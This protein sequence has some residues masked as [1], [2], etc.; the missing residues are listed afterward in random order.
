MSRIYVL[1]STIKKRLE[2]IGYPMTCHKC[3]KRLEANDEV[4]SIG[5]HGKSRRYHKSCYEGMFV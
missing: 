4:V 2:K 1:N 3:K 5:H